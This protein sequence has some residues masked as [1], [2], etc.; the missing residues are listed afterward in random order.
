MRFSDIE[1]RCIYNV[2]FDPV[3][4]CEFNGKHLAVVLKKNNDKKTFIVMPL[5]TVPNGAGVNKIEIGQIATLPTPLKRN[6][7][8]AIITSR[9]E[10]DAPL[11]YHGYRL[12]TKK[13]GVNNSGKE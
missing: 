11:K 8:F 1:V 2:I 6:R 9:M 7:T 5:T 4:A 13:N 10:R 3:E 12:P